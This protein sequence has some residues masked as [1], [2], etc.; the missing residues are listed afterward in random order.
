M[1]ARIVGPTLVLLA[2]VTVVPVPG[3]AAEPRVVMEPVEADG[4]NL[5]KPDAWRPY[6]KGFTRD[7][8]TFVCDNG[9][10]SGARRGVSQTVVLNQK[11]PRPIVAT[12]WSRAEGVGGRPNS[13]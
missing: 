5:L 2:L 1:P 4:E 13:D 9:A 7:G 11:E 12:C 3:T 6:E 8:E 10:D